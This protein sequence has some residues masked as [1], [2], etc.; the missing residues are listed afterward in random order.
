MCEFC[1]QHGEGKKWYLNVKNYAIEL[2]NDLNRKNLIRNSYRIIVKEG[3]KSV[4]RLENI[5]RKKK[6]KP[7]RI[8]QVYTKQ[9]KSTHFG[10]VLP[11]ED[12]FKILSFSN[13]IVRMACGCSWEVGKKE[14]RCCFGIS[15]GPPDWYQDVDLSYFGHPYVARLES[16]KKEEAIQ[17]IQELDRKG[18]VHS[19]WTFQTPFIGTICN[20]DRTSCLAMRTTVGLKMSGMFRAEN[21]AIIDAEKCSGCQACIEICPFEAVEYSGTDK[22]CSVDVKKCFGCGIC[23]NICIEKAIFLINRNTHPVASSVW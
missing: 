5:F 19:V 3:N 9:M 13:S 16:L 4:S 11:M 23:R 6:K 10:Q 18:L 22:K 2:L 7:E 12:V 15:Y 8:A 1:T 14:K 20:C 17:C 21:V